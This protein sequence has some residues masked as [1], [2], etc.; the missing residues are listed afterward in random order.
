MY[1]IDKSKYEKCLICEKTITEIKKDYGGTGVYFADAFKKHVESHNIKIEE[2][3]EKSLKI[4]R[5]LCACGICNK[6][7]FIT[8]KKKNVSGFF[9]KEYMCGRNP[10]LLKWSEEARKGRLGKNNPMFNKAA[11][12]KGET[13]NTNKSVKKISDKRK[14]MIFSEKTKNK[15]SMKPIKPMCTEN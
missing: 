3:F 1:T 14:G 6:Q 7:S 13:K 11:W 15:Q 9:W 8:T 4:T 12:N 5:P 10:G 2:Y